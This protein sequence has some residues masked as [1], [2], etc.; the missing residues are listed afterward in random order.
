MEGISNPAKKKYA[1]QYLKWMEG[2]EEG[3]SPD[4]GKLRPEVAETVRMML[5]QGEMGK[6]RRFVIYPDR[7]QKCNKCQ[8]GFR[9]ILRRPIRRADVLKKPEGG[10]ADQV[11]EGDEELERCMKAGQQRRGR[12]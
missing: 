2:G 10:L 3:F 12:K 8:G 4:P 11:A 7:L 1:T 6:S 9:A 5:R